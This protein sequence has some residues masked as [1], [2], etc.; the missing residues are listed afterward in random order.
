VIAEKVMLPIITV[1]SQ[2]MIITIIVKYFPIEKVTKYQ[3]D[4]HQMMFLEITSLSI[5]QQIIKNSLIKQR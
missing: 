1:T 2:K 3:K 4:P 5:K